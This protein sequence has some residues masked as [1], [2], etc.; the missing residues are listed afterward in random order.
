MAVGDVRIPMAPLDT[1]KHTAAFK[2]FNYP[3]LCSIQAVHLMTADYLKEGGYV[4]SGIGEI[5]KAMMYKFV[6]VRLKIV[7]MAN[8]ADEGVTF[9]LH[10]PTDAPKI[11]QIIRQHLDDHARAAKYDINK[12]KVPIDDLRKL[13]A[14][15]ELV[16][17]ISQGMR[18]ANAPEETDF[19]KRLRE[20]GG[21]GF[22]SKLRVDAPKEEAPKAPEPG[23]QSAMPEIQKELG[24][25]NKLWLK[26]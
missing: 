15:A 10:N 4:T 6:P 16:Y 24:V 8:F 5:D 13:D 20:F 21:R 17:P 18:D 26:Q 3:F 23:Y 22:L 14:L 1:S 11:Y 2:I 19:F 25:R 7:H 9:R 12:S